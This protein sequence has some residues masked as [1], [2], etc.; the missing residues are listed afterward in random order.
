MQLWVNYS[1]HS[2]YDFNYYLTIK[3]LFIQHV[4][5]LGDWPWMVALGYRTSFNPGPLFRCGGTLISDR[6]VLTAAHCVQ[7]IG[8]S[9]LLVFFLFFHFQIARNW[10]R[11]I[12]YRI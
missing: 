10:F 11:L 4:E 1:A 6:W 9:V 5:F 2:D 12:H 8:D 7:Y 3:L